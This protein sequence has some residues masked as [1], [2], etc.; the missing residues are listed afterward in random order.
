MSGQVFSQV[1]ES[2]PA[3]LVCGAHPDRENALEVSPKP[4]RDE[5]IAREIVERRGA[6]LGSMRGRYI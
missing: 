3:K 6:L 2:A 1:G 5:L 4:L